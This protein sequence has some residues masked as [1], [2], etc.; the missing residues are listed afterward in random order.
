MKL[1][2]IHRSIIAQA[3]ELGYF[4][5]AAQAKEI[6]LWAGR[7]GRKGMTQA[8]ITALIDRSIVEFM[9]NVAKKKGG[10]VKYGRRSQMTAAGKDAFNS[11]LATEAARRSGQPC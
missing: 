4:P 3:N 2:N 1:A 10:K 5:M 9:E 8:E 6:N 7:S 11:W